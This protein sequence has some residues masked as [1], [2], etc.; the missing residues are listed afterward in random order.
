MKQADIGG[1]IK[2]GFGDVSISEAARRLKVA[3]PGLSNLVSGKT[4][5]TKAMAAKLAQVFPVDGEALMRCERPTE[6]SA[7]AAI[8]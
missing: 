3:R 5:L 8:S 1:V 4:R 2:A 7:S 6:T